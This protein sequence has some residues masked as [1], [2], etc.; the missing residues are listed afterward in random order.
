MGEEKLKSIEYFKTKLMQLKTNKNVIRVFQ[1]A[2]KRNVKI[3]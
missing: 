1:G 2:E 3:I